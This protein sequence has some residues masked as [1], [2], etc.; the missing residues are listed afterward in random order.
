M[1]VAQVKTLV[2]Q[3]KSPINHSKLLSGFSDTKD[4]SLLLYL[5]EMGQHDLLGSRER[6]IEI[7]EQIYAAQERKIS[8]AYSPTNIVLAYFSGVLEQLAP[9]YEEFRRA[10]KGVLMGKKVRYQDEEDI[11]LCINDY[12]YLPGKEKPQQ[13]EAYD[14]LA[15]DLVCARNGEG[16]LTRLVAASLKRRS[17]DDT[18]SRDSRGQAIEELRG[19]NLTLFSRWRLKEP[20]LHK[21]LQRIEEES[22]EQEREYSI[23]SRD[24]ESPPDPSVKELEKLVRKYHLDFSHDTPASIRNKIVLRNGDLD[25][26]LHD[27]R[28]AEQDYISARDTMINANLRLVVRLAKGFQQRGVQFSDLVQ[29]GNIGLMMAVEKYNWRRGY[30]FST[31]AS[32]W[33]LSYITWELTHHCR[34]IRIPHHAHYFVYKISRARSELMMILE[35]EPSRSEVAE[36]LSSELEVVEDAAQYSRPLA[37]LDAPLNDTDVPLGETIPGKM[38]FTGFGSGSIQA[39]AH[40]GLSLAMDELCKRG[41]FTKRE[42]T[43]LEM[44]YGINQEDERDYTLE[45]IGKKFGISRERVRQ[46]EE[47][48]LRKLKRYKFGELKDLI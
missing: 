26:V 29:N 48:A 3:K 47:K 11:S 41:S 10:G 30:R 39:D 2:E 44:H 9:A 18:C 19:D 22:A 12:F 20:H 42:R 14:Q 34:D 4:K 21:L 36:H 8:L 24:G 31:H 33:I 6:E 43:I 25:R 15:F 17:G 38:S 46:I 13:L 40:E 35:R 1:M 7:M 45:E 37:Y 28:R 23:L 5:N 32:N 27:Y 16:K